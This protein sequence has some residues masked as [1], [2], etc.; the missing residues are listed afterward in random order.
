MRP[1]GRH[2]VVKVQRRRIVEEGHRRGGW[3]VVAGCLMRRKEVSGCL[4]G[5]C[6]RERRG[7][8]KME[9]EKGQGVRCRRRRRRRRSYE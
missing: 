1:K 3:E 2:E 5:H 8:K 7:V 6:R 9:W 4:R